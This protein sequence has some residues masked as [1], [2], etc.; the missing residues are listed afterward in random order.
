MN[1]IKIMCLEF[2]MKNKNNGVRAWMIE[3]W[4][5]EQDEPYEGLEVRRQIYLDRDNARIMYDR[6][7]HLDDVRKIVY[8]EIMIIPGHVLRKTIAPDISTRHELF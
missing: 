4:H 1:K 3:S 7:C 5:G 6:I 8:S 2:A